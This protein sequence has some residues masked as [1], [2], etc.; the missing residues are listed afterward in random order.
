MDDNHLLGGVH[1]E[2]E[3]GDSAHRHTG[4]CALYARETPGSGPPVPG[5]TARMEAT[6]GILRHT[7]DLVD[8][9]DLPQTAEDT[10]DF[11]D[12]AR[13]ATAEVRRIA[14]AVTAEGPAWRPDGMTELAA[15]LTLTDAER[16]LL[17]YALDQ[18]QEHIWS[19]DGFTD[20]DQAAVDSLKRIAGEDAQS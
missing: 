12:G 18:A 11:H 4:P 3:C 9:E 1:A 6:A 15:G 5:D 20:E 8:R 2:P 10:S 19:R 17:R 7:A 14:D 13:W 16:T